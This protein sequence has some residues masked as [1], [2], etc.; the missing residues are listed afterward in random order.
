MR[1]A[2]NERWTAQLYGQ[3]PAN[4]NLENEYIVYSYHDTLKSAIRMCSR[5]RNNGHPKVQVDIVDGYYKNEYALCTRK[6]YLLRIIQRKWKRLYNNWKK[7]L[8]KNLY[9]IQ[10]GQLKLPPKII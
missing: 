6:T 4:L 9:K 2:V 3:A 8:T 1:F 10:I 5:V 7:S